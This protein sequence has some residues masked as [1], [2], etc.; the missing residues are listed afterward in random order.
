[1]ITVQLG[2]KPINVIQA[3][4]PAVKKSD[5][6]VEQFYEQLGNNINTMY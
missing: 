6:N 1:M 3:G 2:C 5:T 4:T